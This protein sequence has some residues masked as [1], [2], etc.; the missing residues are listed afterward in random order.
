[1]RYSRDSRRLCSA[2]TGTNRTI[3]T[4]QILELS[5]I[6]DRVLLEKLNIPVKLDLPAVGKNVQGARVAAECWEDG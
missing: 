2:L 1:V 6:G 4:P 3:K 5:G